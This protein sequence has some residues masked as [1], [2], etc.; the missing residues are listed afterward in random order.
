[1]SEPSNDVLSAKLDFI[2]DLLLEKLS[3]QDKRIDGTEKRIDGL[4]RSV[5]KKADK[6]EFK[7]LWG[8]IT[9]GVWIVLGA[10]ITALVAMVVKTHGG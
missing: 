5:D 1:M 2:K 8:H 6:E 10:V 7:L 9:K 3:H 4:E